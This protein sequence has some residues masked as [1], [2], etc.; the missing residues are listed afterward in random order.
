MINGD[1]NDAE[2]DY[3][4]MPRHGHK[5]TKYKICLSIMVICIKQH[6]TNILNLIHEN[7]KHHRGYIEKRVAYKKSV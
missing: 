7:F 6:L 4:D 1:E 3:K 5:Y 2:N